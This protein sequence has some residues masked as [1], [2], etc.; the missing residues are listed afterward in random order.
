MSE[1]ENTN[2]D[3]NSREFRRGVE[4]GLD[5]EV[6]K[7]WQAGYE[8]GQGLNDKE[9]TKEPVKEFLPEEPDTPLF[10]KD[11]LDGHD[12]DAMG[13]DFDQPFTDREIAIAI[14]DADGDLAGHDLR[15]Q[16]RVQRHDANRPVERRQQDHVH[17]FGHRQAFRCDDV[18]L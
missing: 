17:V 15:H 10:L 14:G 11:T 8:L 3:A 5:S 16:M 9:E 6:T 4:A 2:S 12:G 13:R 7:F 18:E 1:I